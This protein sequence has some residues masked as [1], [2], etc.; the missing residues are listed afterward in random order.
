M[1][2][3]HSNWVATTFSIPVS[4]ANG[5]TGATT[6]TSNLPLIGNGTGAIAQG[7]RSGNTTTFATSTGSLTNGHCVSIDASGNFIDAGGACTTGGGGGTVASGTGN[8]LGYYATSGTTI[9][10][11]ATC[12]SGVYITSGAGVPSCSTTIPAT[13]QGNITTVGTI[14]S[15]TWGGSVIG[16]GVGGT[17]VANASTITVGGTFVTAG[18]ASLPSI[19]QGDIWYGSAS[20][21]ISALPLSSTATRYLA[22]TGSS[23][24]PAWAQVSL[25]NGVTGNLPTSNLNSGTSA[26]SSTF[27]RGDGTWA[28]PSAGSIAASISANY[29]I[30]T[31][32]NQK[33]FSISGSSI[34]KIGLNT[35]SVGCSTGS[36][37]YAANFSVYLVNNSTRG[38]LITIAS[39]AAFWIMPGQWV[40]ISQ[41]AANNGWIVTPE[42]IAIGS[43]IYLAEPLN[44]ASVTDCEHTF[45]S[46]SGSDTAND[47]LSSA[48]PFRQSC[49]PVMAL[50]QN[51]MDVNGGRRSFKLRMGITARPSGMVYLAGRPQHAHPQSW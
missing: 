16:S 26:S 47:G 22:N 6:F 21:V 4:V 3:A 25:V 33:Y 30:A 35:N 43:A 9:T 27:W 15:G 18:A 19:S 40:Q 1:S 20:G 28:S 14:S 11:L 2:A 37:S 17:G 31:T 48:T 12:N 34:W 38:D 49:R 8:Q 50:T 45:F 42:E 32:D 23:N 29:C 7:T 51:Y 10:G 44:G 36:S 41:N 13:T 24:N 5:G 39:N 46:T